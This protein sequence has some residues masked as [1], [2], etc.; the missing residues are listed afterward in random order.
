MSFPY[1]IFP[2]CLCWA[3]DAAVGGS[4]VTSTTS[5]AVGPLEPKD[6][7]PFFSRPETKQAIEDIANA[8]RLTI[9]VGAGASSEVGLPNWHELMTRLLTRVGRSENLTGTEL[10]A[11]LTWAIAS[12]GLP[13]VGSIA[14]AAFGNRFQR[15]LRRSLYES[16]REPLL[17]GATARAVAE[18]CSLWGDT[19][20]VVTTNYDDLLESA[21][22]SA[23]PRSKV[24]SRT[25]EYDGV[26]GVV[27]VRHLHGIMTPSSTRGRLILS[28][29]DYYRGANPDAWQET[30][31]RKRFGDSTCLFIGSSMSDP[32]LLRYLYRHSRKRQVVILLVRQADTWPGAESLESPIRLARERVALLRWQE[33]RV[34]ALH[35]D[36]YNQSAQFLWEVAR[37]RKLGRSYESYGTRIDRWASYTADNI[38]RLDDQSAFAESQDRLQQQARAWLKTVVEIIERSTHL[39]SDERLAIH[40]WTRDPNARSLIMAVSSDR[41]WRD[42]KILRPQKIALPSTWAAVNAFC[43]G[44]PCVWQ[45]DQVASKW[46]Y[47][48]AIPIH[49]EE[50]PLGRLPVGVVCIASTQ[51]ANLS[52]LARLKPADMDAVSVYLTENAADLLTPLA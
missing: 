31:F 4:S 3:I 30:F 7:R 49:I 43:R 38:L 6:D 39:A 45:V 25:D 21:L 2:R 48:R 47:I 46:G 42:P 19:C 50:K 51:P 26:P 22:A 23:I 16:V 15:E 10:E 20:E 8:K 29:A 11:F 33:V 40:L 13:A 5:S 35:T 52:A 32:N 41:S 37:R 27:E 34:T 14:R 28:E 17:P 9:F 18:I 24:Q 44:V 1:G 36:F 12:E